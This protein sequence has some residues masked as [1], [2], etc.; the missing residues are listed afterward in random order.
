MEL[1]LL[2]FVKKDNNGLLLATAVISGAMLLWPF[3]RRSTGGP[4][5]S[6]AQ[7]TQL[8]TREDALVLDVRTPGEYQAGHILGAK[9]QP[10]ERLDAV[11]VSKRKSQPLIVYCEGGQR[12][13]KAAALLRKQGFEKVV[14]LHGG[15]GAWQQAGLPIEK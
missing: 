10:L 12:S 8:I 4:W 2:E 7:A 9:N 13:Q 14:N 11:E 15:L 5:V 1:S 3:V 6:T